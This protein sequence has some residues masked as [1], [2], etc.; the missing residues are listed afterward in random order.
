[1]LAFVSQCE[2]L[3][4]LGF[5]RGSYKCVCQDGFYFPFMDLP[6]KYFNG[7]E[8]ENEYEKKTKVRMVIKRNLVIDNL[9]LFKVVK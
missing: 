5:K 3:R 8:I 4:G 7:S 1:M 2:P 6:D 9:H